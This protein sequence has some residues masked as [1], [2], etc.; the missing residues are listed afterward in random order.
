[1]LIRFFMFLLRS[2]Y[3]TQYIVDN[4][5]VFELILNI[6]PPVIVSFACI[7]FIAV[8]YKIFWSCKRLAWC[9]RTFCTRTWV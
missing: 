7:I 8:V 1:M 9:P 2:S 3:T 5:S 4:L 6:A